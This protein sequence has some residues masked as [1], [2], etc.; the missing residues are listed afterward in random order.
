MRCVK[1]TLSCPTRPSW[2]LRIWRLTSRSL[3]GTARTDV[4]VGT[5]SDASMFVTVRAAAPRSRSP[6]S[7]LDGVAGGNGADAGAAGAAAGGPVSPTDG[8]VDGGAGALA[9]AAGVGPP[10][11]K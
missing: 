7:S 1:L 9:A 6:G 3:A 4:A 11:S 2:L 8:A 10:F 5:R